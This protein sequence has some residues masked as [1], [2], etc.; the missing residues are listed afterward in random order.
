MNIS[1]FPTSSALVLGGGGSTGNAWLI[2]MVA[3]LAAE[4]LEVF[5]A[6]L[7]V[8]TSAGATAA[9]QLAGTEP[10]ELYEAALQPI[11]APRR[12]AKK[13]VIDHLAK[14]KMMIS[15]CSSSAE[16]HRVIS[17]ASL[18]LPGAMDAE[19]SQRWRAI[20]GARFEG[21]NWPKQ[22]LIKISAVNASTGL[23]AVFDN[24]S[25]VELVDAVAAS[26]SSSLPF[27]LA[28]QAYIDGGYRR[29]ENADLARGY[30][31]ILVLSP[32]GR[33]SLHPESWKTS[34]A[35]QVEELRGSGS[36]VEV[37][38]P[39]EAAQPLMGANAMDLSL[40]PDAANAGY[41]QG[42]RSAQKLSADL[43]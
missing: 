32:L 38:L 43:G 2:G 35:A 12:G 4:G 34:L 27:W 39:D 29:N 41:L 22:R 10:Q 30:S 1:S 23:P 8:G 7:T 5:N 19:F 37:L 40:R 15:S 14:L 33:R 13:P 20:V 9:A 11:D 26:C 36:K 31:K 6:D 24:Y 18:E 21:S 16:F 42:R 25:G 17:T 28:G 3:G